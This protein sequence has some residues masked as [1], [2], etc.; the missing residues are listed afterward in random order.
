MIYLHYFYLPFIQMC[1]SVII[2]IYILVC[3]V[4]YVFELINF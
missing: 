3:F 1:V 4:F 2:Y